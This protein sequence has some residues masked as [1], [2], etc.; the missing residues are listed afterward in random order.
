MIK[1]LNITSILFVICGT[2]LLSRQLFTEIILRHIRES[3]LT[4]KK[5][6][7]LLFHLRIIA[8]CYGINENNWINIGIFKNGIEKR[9]KADFI[10]PFIGFL[11]VVISGI[12]QILLFI[13]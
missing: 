4:Y 6:K 12:I 9:L 10:T 5:W 3:Q 1:A 13:N 7:D 11:C 2:Y 8:R